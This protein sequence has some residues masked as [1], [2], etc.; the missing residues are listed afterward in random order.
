MSYFVSVILILLISVIGG[1]GLSWVNWKMPQ[2]NEKTWIWRISFL[3]FFVYLGILIFKLEAIQMGG[4]DFGI[5]DSMLHNA[6]SGKGLMRDFRGPFD[7]FSPVFMLFAPLYLI[8]DHPFWLLLIQTGALVFAAPVLYAAAKRY[9]PNGIVPLALA[10]MYLL[11]PYWNRLILYDFHIECLFPLLCFTAFYYY[12]RKKI[13]LFALL[14]LLSPLLKEDFVVPLAAAGLWL[15]TQKG[16]R[17]L[18]FG[19]IGAALLWTLFVLKIY[20]PWILQAGY[21]HYGRYEILDGTPDGLVRNILIMAG[22]VVHPDG[23]AVML[24][25][26]L[27]FA[28]LPTVNWKMLLF[29]WLP[30]VGIQLVS[31]NPNQRYMSCHYAAALVAV[32]PIAALWGMRTLRYFA[33]RFPR[34]RPIRGRAFAGGA[35]VLVLLCHMVYSDLP[36]SR[37]FGYI[38][39][40]PGIQGGILSLPLQPRYWG[41]MWRLLTHAWE[42][43]RIAEELPLSPETVMV[44]QNELQ[45]LFY[46]KARVFD[47]PELGMGNPGTRPERADIYVMDSGNYIGYG[48]MKTVNE[49][50]LALAQDPAYELIRYPN[51]IMII[52]KK[53]LLPDGGAPATN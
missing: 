4:W 44:C 9:F 38:H 16:R 25:L 35:V 11:N 33:C 48:D 28:L 27:P 52:M 17:K 2:W 51:G 23:L 3:F 6:A 30:T 39:K 37:Y 8:W 47:F 22:R 49:I 50:L 19:M 41:E 20:F 53:S 1:W 43:E 31:A 14:L 26:L 18:G 15:L 40:V 12:S 13:R 46:R 36:L 34:F 24:S 7:H 21:W 5:Y 29:F 45:P 32:T 42:F 10:L